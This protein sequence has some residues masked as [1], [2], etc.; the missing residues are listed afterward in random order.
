M[1]QDNTKVHITNHLKPNSFNVQNFQLDPSLGCNRT[2]SS[3]VHGIQ[4]LLSDSGWLLW[5]KIT[6][7]TCQ[8]RKSF[9]KLFWKF[10]INH[11]AEGNQRRDCR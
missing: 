1:P 5:N 3:T 4:Y 11:P 2:S 7:V 9:I 6:H 8:E 10:Y